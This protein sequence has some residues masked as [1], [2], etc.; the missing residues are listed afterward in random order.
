MQLLEEEF[1]THNPLLPKKS[2]P[3]SPRVAPL[4]RLEVSTAH[5]TYTYTHSPDQIFILFLLFVL[6]MLPPFSLFCCAQNYC[7]LKIRP[8]YICLHKNYNLSYSHSNSHTHTHTHTLTLSLSYMHTYT[9]THTHTHTR[10]GKRSL[11]GSAG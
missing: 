7:F 1:P 4:L 9:H 2:S 5:S 3:Q 10:R 11:I 6:L 8:S